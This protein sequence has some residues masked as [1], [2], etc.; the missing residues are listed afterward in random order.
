MKLADEQ[1][2]ENGLLK[3]DILIGQNAVHH[4]TNQASI[5]MPGESVLLPT[6]NKKYIL[7]GPVDV[8][9]LENLENSKMQTA[10]PHFLAVHAILSDFGGLKNLEIS[11]RWTKNIHKVY[12]CVSSPEEL[13]IID[14][15]R[16][17][18]L[19]GISPSDYEI[20][21]VLEDFNKTAE[22]NGERYVVRLPFK[23]PQIKKLS[24]NFLQAFQRLMSGHKRRQKEKFAGEREKYE[25]SFK[26]ELDRGILE[27]VDTLGTVGE[28]N[29]KLSKNP[30][31]FNQL[32]LSNGRPCCYLPHQCVYKA[33]TGKFRR[34][35]DGS[36]KPYAGANSVNDCLETGQN[37]MEN[38]LHIVLG[39]RKEPFAAKSDIEK[40]FPQVMIHSDDRDVLRCLW[41]E[42]DQVVVYRFKRLP[43]GLSC[44]PFILQATLR[45]HLGEKELD[46]QT[47]QNFIS[48]LYVDDSVWSEKNLLDL[49]KRKN[50]YTKVFAE[51]G[52]NFRD[53]TSNHPEARAYF[54][55]LENREEK[56]EELVL[57]LKWGVIP[58]TLT[59][60]ANR[61]KEVMSQ[62]LKTKRD[63]WKIVPSVYDPLGLISPFVLIG[64]MIVSAACKEVKSW[65]AKLPSKYVDLTLNWAKDFDKIENV[66]FNRHAGIQNPRKLELYGVSDASAHALGACVYLISTAQD[67][68]IHS[69]L[70]ISKTR[71]APKIEHTIPRLELTAAVLLINLVNHVLKVYQNEKMEV[72]YFSD[73]ADVIFWI[74]SGHFSWKP[75]VAN[76]LKKL[77]KHSDVLSWRHIDGKDNPS[78]L[79][80]RGTPI[81]ELVDNTFWS[82]GPE[83]WKT[84]D[85]S[86]GKS[87]LS[88]YDKHYKNLEMTPMCSK[89]LNSSLKRQLSG[90]LEDKITISSLQAHVL[91]VNLEE[92]LETTP[93]P[94]L[95]LP[96]IDFV[97]DLK[98]FPGNLHLTYENV[99]FY[100][101]AILE[102]VDKFR[103]KKLHVSEDA[104]RENLSYFSSRAELVWIQSM[105]KKYF[106]ELFLLIERPQAIVSAFSR[107]VFKN[108]GIFL[109]KDMKVLR[110]TT[111]NE[112]ALL[113]Y[114]TIYPILLPS[115]VKNSE[116]KWENCLFTELLVNKIHDTIGHQGVPHTLSNLRS[117]FW[118]LQGRRFVQKILA[119]CFMCRKIQGTPYSVPPA[120]C[121]PEFR[122]VRN[123][124]FAGTGVDY[125]GPFNLRE[126]SRGV[127]SKGWLLSFTCGS[128]R[129]LHIE[130]VKSRKIEDFL[131]ALSRFMSFHGIPESFVSD[132]EG[133]FVR[134][135]KELEQIVKS[136]RVQ[137]YLKA[138]R[139]SWHFYTEKAPQ[140]GGFLERL[141]GIIKKSF[142]KSLTNKVITFEEFRTLAAY[143][144]STA[145]DRPLTYVYSDIESENK[146]LTPSMLLRGYNLNEPPHLNLR[147]S[148]DEIETKLSDSYFKL[149][150]IKDA[151]WKTWN[152]QYLT[153]L[154]ERH[155]RN[156]KANKE[157]VKPTLGDVVLLSEDKIPR[158][159][160]RLARVVGIN[161][162]R[163]VVREVTVQTLSP[164]GGQITKLKRTPEKLIPL[165][166]SPQN[167]VPLELDLENKVKIVNQRTNVR[168]INIFEQRSKVRKFLWFTY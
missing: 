98:E 87:T 103:G 71:N 96:R 137:K 123:K 67:G 97:Y 85:L 31:Y 120:A 108:H 129:A 52:M 36:A 90:N 94:K 34:V 64:K 27:K 158:R 2:S 55:K 17:F 10:T 13:E 168:T 44:S 155:V 58:D 73:S 89:E 125:L 162:K 95:V 74:Y 68:S 151:F 161:E 50:M 37:L 101:E 29:E 54:A 154:F 136:K 121:L 100:T 105:Q 118:I 163:G 42:G 126:T 149:E 19:L 131:N 127:I 78:D 22:F 99:M 7:S 61:L 1:A 56:S 91:Q 25:Q 165:A 111:R 132:H 159:N 104:K 15:F 20:D 65:E 23:E 138:R 119:K 88:G 141:N 107:R 157:L 79:A 117:E 144:H 28:I 48:S 122:V 35:H 40:A 135:S 39:F 76:Q 46:E 81:L 77:K 114:S 106:S 49:Y 26:D 45:K 9:N 143:V 41:V 113:D 110:C 150:K 30:Q 92:L 109:D 86:L 4:F 57:G 167:V 75:Y 93:E 84:G 51:C 47:M 142:Y 11:K 134:T 60:N 16:N 153:E 21:P 148:Q 32:T 145:N 70:L 146:A 62:K 160:W 18:E 43:F 24:N 14:T 128:T 38:I 164:K 133:S 72:T 3:V 140:K 53:W 139:I 69:N 130:A 166:V 66:V 156:K 115:S 5:F 147:K 102:A 63:L 12:S 116:G 83:F 80:S 8:E 124:P 112:K 6:W 82:E 59:I 152:K 33:S